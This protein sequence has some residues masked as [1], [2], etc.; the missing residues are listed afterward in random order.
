MTD[1]Y[2]KPPPEIRRHRRVW[3]WLAGLTLIAATL[4]FAALIPMPLAVGLIVLTGVVAV[5][6]DRRE[7]NTRKLDL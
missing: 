6:E 3:P 1:T 5:L 4:A 2:S 7:R